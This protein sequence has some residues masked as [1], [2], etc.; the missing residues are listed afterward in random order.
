MSR[1]LLLAHNCAESGDVPVGA[2]VLDPSGRIIGEG[3]NRREA[4][5]DPTAHAEVLALRA[6]GKKLGSWNLSGCTLVV[7]LEPCTACAGAVV[8]ARISRLVFGAWDEKAGA[9]GSLRD[10]VRDSRLNHQVEVISGVL[11]EPASVQLRGFFAERRLAQTRQDSDFGSRRSTPEQHR[12]AG[13]DADG[14]GALAANRDS[15]L[16]ARRS[17]RAAQKKKAAASQA[18]RAA[19]LPRR[20]PRR[21]LSPAAR[22]ENQ[23]KAAEHAATARAGSVPDAPPTLTTA[24]DL[25]SLPLPE[26][27][28]GEI[29]IVEPDLVTYP[30]LRGSAPESSV[31]PPTVTVTPPLPAVEP[32]LSSAPP[33]GRRAARHAGKRPIPPER[34]TAGSA[35]AG[36]VPPTKIPRT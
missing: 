25:T 34:G 11:E 3:W 27:P 9:C 12:P 36:P 2:V 15:P 19:S 5:N 23:P 7:T 1:A 6:A 29:R 8:G 31:Q 14:P 32:G 26:L 20:R 35:F 18:E 22:T 28:S 10:V 16:P 33:A 4:D 24:L 21:P 17:L 13:A 30:T